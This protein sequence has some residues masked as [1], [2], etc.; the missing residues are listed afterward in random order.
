MSDE[1]QPQSENG[2]LLQAAPGLL[3]IAVGAS[4]RT[5]EWTIATSVRTGERVAR[6][7]LSG[8]SAAEFL[9]EAGTELR[10]QARR[11]LGLAEVMEQAVGVE[12]DRAAGRS[13]NSGGETG[14]LRDRGSALLRQSA[15]VRYEQGAHPA[16]GRILGDLAPDEGR[17][18]RLLALE[19][20]QPA[21]DVRT[22]RPLDLGS[23]L[24]APGLSMIAAHAGC[25]Y[26]ERVPAY[27]DNLN[28]LGLIWF[29]REPLRDPLRYQVLEAQPDVLDAL[30]KAGRGR[31]VRR[32]I[33]LTPFGRD[34]CDTCLPLE[35]AELDA[36][37]GDGPQG[38]AGQDAPAPDLPPRPDSPT[39][40]ARSDA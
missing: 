28:R 20:P 24:V 11:L 32:S 3:R 39:P 35:T 7:A 36:L 2:S 25:R 6:A 8:E 40:D 34:F 30:R 13:G 9:Q 23:E 12:Q 4:I 38:D 18:L 21:V 29:S 5:A 15:D 27:L 1:G 14:S 26:M 17:I 22:W 31:I 33:H 19:G 16:Y 37:P 10:D